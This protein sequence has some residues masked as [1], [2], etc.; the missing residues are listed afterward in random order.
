[1]CVCVCIGGGGRGKR[2]GGR[3]G[4]RD[5]Q[6]HVETGSNKIRIIVRED[7]CVCVCVVW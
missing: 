2:D 7:K 6:K 5:K 1:M 4:G 3:E